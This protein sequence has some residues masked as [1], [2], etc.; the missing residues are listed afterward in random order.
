MIPIQS[1]VPRDA[2]RAEI[3]AQLGR[4]TAL[5]SALLPL[6]EAPVNVHDD[7]PPAA[8]ISRADVAAARRLLGIGTSMDTDSATVAETMPAWRRWLANA[9]PG[10]KC[11]YY[12]GFLAGSMYIIKRKGEPTPTE[13]TK[14]PVAAEALDACDHGLVHL[15][16]V[17]MAPS[18]YRYYAIRAGAAAVVPLKRRMVRHVGDV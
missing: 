1:A 8:G 3:T 10:D 18:N 4:I 16:Q 2:L 14:P 12:A 17:K 15:V 13:R 6:A 9:Q 11:M 7:A 5:E